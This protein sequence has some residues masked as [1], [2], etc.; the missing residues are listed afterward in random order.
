MKSK[1]IPFN[2]IFAAGGLGT[3]MGMEIPK[4]F[5]SLANKP[6]ALHSFELFLNI[7]EVHEIVIVCEPSFEHYFRQKNT[8]KKITFA[9]PGPRRQDS[10]Y[11][12]L[13]ALNSDH[14]VCIH[15]SA[16]PAVKV[17][18]VRTV[19]EMASNF[20]AAVLGVP[21]KGTIKIC[22]ENKMIAST[23]ERSKL[24]EMQTP[25]VIRY[26]WFTDA[27]RIAIDKNLTVTDDVSLVELLGKPVKIVEGC[28][29]NIKAT[30][31]EDLIVL[32]KLLKNHV[33]L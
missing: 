12:G 11:N 31:P 24:W 21:V 17:K 9:V 4:Q 6:L 23:P 22:D 3:R 15:D 14:L 25:Q 19:V 2:V 26:Q 28:Y 8:D 30:T 7:P 16:R 18:N 29:S 20:G 27:Y 10:V 13:Q 1:E 32:E 5:I 33:L